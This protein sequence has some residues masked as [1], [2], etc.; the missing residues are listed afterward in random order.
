MVVDDEQ[1]VTELFKQ[2]FRKE[3]KLG[4]IEFIF[5]HSAEKALETLRNH[6]QTDAVLILSDINMPGMNGLE[7]LH[8]LKNSKPEIKVIMVTAYNDDE[9]YEK[10]MQYGADGFINK[11][12]DFTSLKET[13][14][15][16]AGE[17]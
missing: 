2:R 17:K 12:I 4:L 15:Q 11:P 14:Y 9:N 3:I 5:E 6:G 16:V 7:L 10:A 13:I 1:D 8:I